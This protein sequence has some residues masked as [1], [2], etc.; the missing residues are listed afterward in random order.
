MATVRVCGEDKIGGQFSRIYDITEGLSSLGFVC[1]LVQVLTAA[2]WEG[3]GEV[4]LLSTLSVHSNLIFLIKQ[5]YNFRE[6]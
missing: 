1:A 3:G 6:K 5:G 4:V 2:F